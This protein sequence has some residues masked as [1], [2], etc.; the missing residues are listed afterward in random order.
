MAI[1]VNHRSSIVRSPGTTPVQALSNTRW[2]FQFN[3]LIVEIGHRLT[4]LL[5]SLKHPIHPWLASIVKKPRW[6]WPI[7]PEAGG[8]PVMP[9]F[10]LD[11]MWLPE[12]RCK[13]S[14]ISPCNNTR[15]QRH[16][17]TCND[18]TNV[19]DTIGG[20]RSVLIWQHQDPGTYV[21]W[22]ACPCKSRSRISGKFI[23]PYQYEWSVYGHVRRTAASD[24]CT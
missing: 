23:S 5:G 12:S 22:R 19:C 2:S 20:I 3:R 11:H 14:G 8:L 17:A 16:R 13:N 4:G 24:I 18:E 10:S 6:S 21:N 7:T 9:S 1:L 15:N